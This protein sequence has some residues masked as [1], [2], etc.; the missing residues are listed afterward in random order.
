VG[1][2]SPLPIPGDQRAW[3]GLVSVAGRRYGVEA[4][5]APR[6]AQALVRRLQL[7]IRD[8]AVDGVILV[9]STSRGAADF[10]AGARPA[11]APMLPIP[12]RRALELLGVGVDPGGSSLVTIA[13]PP[14]RRLPRR[15]ATATTST[16]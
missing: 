15:Q 7:K 3:D 16:G 6:D 12:G 10:V 11:L 8:G 14:Q 9:V 13:I 1:D 5:T 2:R 4:E